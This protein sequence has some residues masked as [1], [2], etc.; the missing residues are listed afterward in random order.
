MPAESTWN[1]RENPI[2]EAVFEAEEAGAEM[3][4][5]AEA[6]EAAGLDYEVARRTVRALHEDGFVSGQQ[7]PLSEKQGFLMD[8]RLTGKGR[9][10]IGQWPPGPAEALIAALDRQIAAARTQT[11]SRSSSGS[12]AQ[13]CCSCAMSAPR[14]LARSWATP[15]LAGPCERPRAGMSPRC[16]HG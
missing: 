1:D 15:P 13:L 5:T 8:L 6:A 16:G 2:L 9:R 3:F 10:R 4:T 14:R 11:S 12:V 7:G